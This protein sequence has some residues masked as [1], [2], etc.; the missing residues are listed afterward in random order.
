MGSL[1][2]WSHVAG[3]LPRRRLACLR[4]PNSEKSAVPQRRVGPLVSTNRPESTKHRPSTPVVL[5]KKFGGESN[6]REGKAAW[7]ITGRA[8]VMRFASTTQLSWQAAR[9]LLRL[10]VCNRCCRLHNLKMAYI[11]YLGKHAKMMVRANCDVRLTSRETKRWKIASA[12]SQTDCSHGDDVS[13]ALLGGNTPTTG[14]W[15]KMKIGPTGSG[16]CW[17]KSRA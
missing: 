1:A 9:A 2:C 12:S 17:Y 3:H 8:A 6:R 11:I 4:W 14:C 15:L 16:C 7:N 10:S 13:R 5:E